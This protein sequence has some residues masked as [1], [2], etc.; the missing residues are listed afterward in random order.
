MHSIS[1]S[2]NDTTSD[3]END[4]PLKPSFKYKSEPRITL[5]KNRN[6]QKSTKLTNSK[7]HTEGQGFVK[8]KS[9]LPKKP[10]YGM[11][12]RKEYKPNIETRIQKQMN[13]HHVN[14]ELPNPPQ[15]TISS[16]PVNQTVAPLACHQVYQIIS[17][18]VQALAPHLLGVNVLP[19]SAY[20]LCQ[21]HFPST[22]HTSGRPHSFNRNH[23]ISHQG[24]RIPHNERYPSRFNGTCHRCNF[25][26]HKASQCGA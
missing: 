2:A 19:Q 24:N 18:N 22:Q 13:R 16:Y 9:D 4:E 12:L 11:N 3:S 14:H 5:T 21:T 20:S 6:R 26:G 1:D 10:R 17:P 15:I 8:V 25:W 23:N 7:Y